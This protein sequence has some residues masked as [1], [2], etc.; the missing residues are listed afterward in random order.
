MHLHTHTP[1][2]MD[3]LGP[4]PVDR[5]EWAELARR[6]AAGDPTILVHH[7]ILF[8]ARGETGYKRQYRGFNGDRFRIQLKDGSEVL[9]HNLWQEGEVPADWLPDFPDNV[10]SWVRWGGLVY[11]RYGAGYWPEGHINA[12]RALVVSLTT[13]AHP[14]TLWDAARFASEVM[15]MPNL[16][17]CERCFRV[18][19]GPCTRCAAV[20]EPVR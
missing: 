2:T 12:A 10:E 3:R 16:N 7:G 5:R 20:E 18:M 15:H 13:N 9:T 17:I 1:D 4:P 19:D 14:T 6:Y 11:Y 8:I